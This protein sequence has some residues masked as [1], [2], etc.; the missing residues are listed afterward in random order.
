MQRDIIT[1]LEQWKNNPTKKPLLLQGARQVG[2]TWLMLE[3]GRKFYAKTAYISFVDNQ[4]AQ[5]I[6]AKDYNIKQIIND[7]GLLTDISVTPEDTL[8]ILDEIQECDRALNCLKYFCENAPEYHIIA[9]GSLLG[10][11]VR[12]KKLSFPVGK[13]EIQQLEPLSFMEFLS[14]L[15]HDKYRYIIENKDYESTNLISDKLTSLLK[16]YFYV[17]GM[18][19]A[20][21]SFS[22][23]KDFQKVRSIQQDIL[24]GYTRDFSKY[25]EPKDVLRILAIWKSL[26]AQLGKENK[27]FAYNLV[28]PGARAREYELALEWLLQCGLVTK[29]RRITKPDL[30]LTAYC[31]DNI[32]KLYMSDIGL[33]AALSHLDSK[34]IL[35]GSKIFEEFKGALTEQYVF[36]VLHINHALPIAYWAPHSGGAEVDFLAQI[37]N[38]IIPIEVKANTNLRSRSLAF[39]REKH[40]PPHAI[41]TSLANY[42]ENNNLYNL[43]LYC[44]SNYDCI[45]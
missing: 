16:E 31:E 4:A 24:D 29:V 45:K 15:G 19:E 6:F 2:K 1:K 27:K 41:R 23:Q 28:A 22:T 5:G 30:P 12:A 34:T 18:P 37:N 44:F 25:A 36:Q 10:V 32:F 13:V 33:L 9:A 35:E 39:Y 26:P 38:Q 3:F 43:P 17:G 14:A 11:A 7:I 8:I 21:L 42:E 20:V 40:N